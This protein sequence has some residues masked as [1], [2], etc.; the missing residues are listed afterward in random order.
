M[1]NTFLTLLCFAGFAHAATLTNVLVSGQIPAPFV[2]NT[3]LLRTYAD[4]RPI[5]NSGVT[6]TI[7]GAEVYSSH[8]GAITAIQTGLDAP[9]LTL[10]S[11]FTYQLGF[12]VLDPS[13]NGYSLTLGHNI[14]GYLNAIYNIDN[15]IP[16]TSIGARYQG[17]TVEWLN[18]SNNWI[19][20][21]NLE[22]TPSPIARADED[23]PF[24]SRLLLDG[25]SATAFVLSGTRNFQFRFL[26]DLAAAA[27]PGASG[28]AAVRLGLDPCSA[29]PSLTVSCTPGLDGT[30]MNELGHFVT[31][32]LDS[33]GGPIENAV[34]EPATLFTA[35]LAIVIAARV[36][37]RN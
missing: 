10:T 15:S 13:N 36:K 35:A 37:Y 31:V 1:K 22:L 30:P 17:I 23:D 4:Y 12:T 34:P 19:P 25:A 18:P 5:S 24:A 32:R 14:V 11:S 9:D 8:Y 20:I 21:P 2:N 26:F 3:F 33:F 7:D 29:L 6:T 28:E 16:G 27:G